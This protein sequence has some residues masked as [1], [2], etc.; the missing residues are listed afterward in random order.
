MMY[1]VAVMIGALLKELPLVVS[2]LAILVIG[3]AFGA[4]NAWFITQLSI[5]P[6]IVTLATLFIGRGLALYLSETKMVFQSDV[7]RRSAA[8]LRSA[9]PG[10]SGSS[11]LVAVVAWVVL[12][13]T[14][15]GRQIYAVGADPDAAAKAG[16][17]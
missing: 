15:Y 14:P 2:F 13:Q 3:L 8:P 5:A 6:F 1:L 17:G 16:I 9:F 12:T 7:S 11:L 4:I 10:R